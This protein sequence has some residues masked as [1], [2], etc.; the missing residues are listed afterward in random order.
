MVVLAVIKSSS[1][2]PSIDTAEEDFYCK[3]FVQSAAEGRRAAGLIRLNL[4]KNKLHNLRLRAR[5]LAVSGAH[6][7]VSALR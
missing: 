5:R 2:T 6:T 3:L 7:S 4:T 1:S